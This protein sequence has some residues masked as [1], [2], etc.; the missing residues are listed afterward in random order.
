MDDTLPRVQYLFPK[1]LKNLF[2][3]A[4]RTFAILNHLHVLFPD[5]IISYWY[6][7]FIPR[8]QKGLESHL[9]EV[10]QGLFR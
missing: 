10:S 2:P 9:D 8:S 4:S 5:T 1:T 3:S 6:R 7:D